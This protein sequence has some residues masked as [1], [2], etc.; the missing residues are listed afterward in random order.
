VE[1][2]RVVLGRVRD[3]GIDA[4]SIEHVSEKIAA[5]GDQNSDP[6][7]TTDESVSMYARWQ[8]ELPGRI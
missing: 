3:K 8:E 2:L 4:P 6:V 5:L 1:D 7:T